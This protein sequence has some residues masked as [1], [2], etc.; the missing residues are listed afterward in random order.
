MFLEMQEL[1][2]QVGRARRD[3]TAWQCN[4]ANKG[5]KSKIQWFPFT[6]CKTNYSPRRT[7]DIDMLRSSGK[8]R[9]VGGR[10]DLPCLEVPIAKLGCLQKH[11]ESTHSPQCHFFPAVC[12]FDVGLRCKYPCKIP[13]PSS[14]ELEQHSVLQD[15]VEAVQ[16]LLLETCWSRMLGIAQ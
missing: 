14:F 10:L 16:L 12:G 6:D 3:A 13:V 9:Q 1:G 11:K 7:E 2:V 5:S 15:V 4:I 8:F